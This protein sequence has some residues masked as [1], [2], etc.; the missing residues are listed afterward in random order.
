MK[1]LN[2]LMAEIHL[3]QYL[4]TF[5]LSTI[6]KCLFMFHFVHMFFLILFTKKSEPLIKRQ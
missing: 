3:L 1:I 2:L 5:Y 4:K 6:V